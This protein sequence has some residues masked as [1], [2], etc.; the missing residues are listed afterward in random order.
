ME[1][2][3]D[4][5]RYLL[6]KDPGRNLFNK[7]LIQKNGRTFYEGNARLN[8]YLHIAQ[9]LH[10]AKTGEPLFSEDLLAYDNGAVA[11]DVQ[12][13]YSILYSRQ[14]SPVLQ[15]DVA[16][17]LDRIFVFL[18]DAT[19]DELIEISHEDEAWE[20]KSGFHSKEQQKMNSMSYVE[21]YKEQYQDALLVLGAI[22]I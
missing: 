5:A 13:N 1:R 11:T 21:K 6:S 16:E 19:V 12:E 9:N 8:K 14:D 17:F 7:N 22:Q 10:I 3:I 4:I 2:A 15:A 18:K 20:E